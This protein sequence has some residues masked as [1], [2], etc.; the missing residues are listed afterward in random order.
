MLPTQDNQDVR[1]A[2]GPPQD[3]GVP[4]RSTPACSCLDRST[5]A[6]SCPD[7]QAE[8]TRFT[9]SPGPDI[10]QTAPLHPPPFPL[11]ATLSYR[12]SHYTSLL[13][14]QHLYNLGPDRAGVIVLIHRHTDSDTPHYTHHYNTVKPRKDT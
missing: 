11:P 6:C 3:L 13:L 14:H 5:P 2:T 9:S 10:S 4:Y 7:R 8:Y 12:P 1:G